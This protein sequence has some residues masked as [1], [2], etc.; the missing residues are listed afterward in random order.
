MNILRIQPDTAETAS[1]QDNI[2]DGNYATDEIWT[3]P[4]MD[5][6]EDGENCSPTPSIT[7]KQIA[8][9]TTTPNCRIDSLCDCE[10]VLIV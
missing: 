9:F 6:E 5:E 10:Y 1:G 8:S 2:N 4:V 3:T 7:T